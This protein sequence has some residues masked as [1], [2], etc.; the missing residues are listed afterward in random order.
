[1]QTTLLNALLNRTQEGMQVSG[2]IYFNGT[3]N[4]S[5]GQINTVSGYVRQGDGMLLT[6]LTVRETLNYA[7]E[8]GMGKTL[9][10]A[11]KRARVEEVIELMDLQECAG[12]M[13]GSSEKSGC[14][15]NEDPFLS[16]CNLSTSPRVCSLMSPPVS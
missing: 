2:D 6:H 5:I 11:E 1:M 15:V 7:A 9:S 16:G 4:P 3:K 13:I 12:V 8:L 14:S 10:A